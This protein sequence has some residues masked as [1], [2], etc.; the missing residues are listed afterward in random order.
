MPRFGDRTERLLQDGGDAPGLVARRRVGVHGGAEV[1]G[2][3]L[4]PGDLVHQ[5]PRGR[6]AGRAV[7][8]QRFRA[9]DLGGLGEHRSST[10]GD[11]QVGRVAQRG[12]GRQPRQ[13]VGA[14]TVEPE[15]QLADRT[16][17]THERVIDSRQHLLDAFQGRLHGRA[18]AA[19]GLDGHAFLGDTAAGVDLLDHQIDLIDLAAQADDHH[20]ADVGVSGETGEGALQQVQAIG[21]HPAAH[22]MNQRDDPVDVRIVVQ[23]AAAD[24]L[25]GDDLADV[26]RAV[27]RRQHR[28]VVAGC[29]GAVIAAHPHEGGSFRCGRRRP[30]MVVEV[31]GLRFVV[32]REDQIVHMDVLSGLDGLQRDTDLIAV[33]GD[34]LGLGDVV[35]GDLVTQRNDIEHRDPGVADRQDL[36]RKEF[37]T[38]H[39]DIIGVVQHQNCVI[40]RHPHHPPRSCHG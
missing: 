23:Q 17:G 35:Q 14:A 39:R 38:R 20:P 40:G 8:Q 2:V 1:G 10:L 27:H 5:A 13:T 12:V 25:V 24:G 7:H 19:G 36:A 9:V 28:N 11:D 29:G 18:G 32:A 34:R 15:H 22:P 6:L 30:G 4:P 33:L 26:G 16:L 3:V 21:G 31:G 37:A